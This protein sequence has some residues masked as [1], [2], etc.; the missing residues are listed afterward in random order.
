MQQQFEHA[1]GAPGS[2][3]EFGEAALT[4]GLSVP[5]QTDF[6]VGGRK[7]PDAVSHGSGPGQDDKAGGPGEETEVFFHLVQGDPMGLNLDYILVRQRKVYHGEECVRLKKIETAPVCR[8][9]LSLR[10]K[11]TFPH[12]ML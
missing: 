12:N 11:F 2:R 3:D 5:G 4:G 7:A 10:A 1:G 6:P 8:S 9:D